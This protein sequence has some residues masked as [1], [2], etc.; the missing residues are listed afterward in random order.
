MS[1]D[2]MNGG[3]RANILKIAQESG[4]KLNQEDEAYMNKMLSLPKGVWI[5]LD[6]HGDPISQDEADKKWNDHIS[7]FKP[8]K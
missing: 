5:P 3:I 7:Q 1:T 4:T 2:I 8:I 6:E